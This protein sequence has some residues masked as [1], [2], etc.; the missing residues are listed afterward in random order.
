M[1]VPTD[2]R[3]NDGN[4]SVLPVPGTENSSESSK[5]PSSSSKESSSRSKRRDSRSKSPRGRRHRSKS[6]SIS[7]SNRGRQRDPRLRGRRSRSPNRGPR[8]PPRSRK[9]GS[10]DRYRSSRR[11]WSPRKK[12]PVSP[13][14][15]QAVNPFNMPPPQIYS[16]GYNYTQP[17][18]PPAPYASY[19]YSMQTQAPFN[20]Y[21][22]AGVMQPVP[23]GDDFQQSGWGHP[24]HMAIPPPTLVIPPPIQKPVETEEEKL[25][26]EA[27]VAK[28]KKTQR[29]TL[30][31]Q[32][33]DYK[34][35]AAA[36]KRELNTLKE[37]RDD[38]TS[39]GEPP[40]PT[41]KGFI[42]EN[43]RL[44][45]QIDNKITSIENVIEVL[46]NIIGTE[47]T[48]PTPS[49]PPPPTP[50]KSKKDKKK[51]SNDTSD[52]DSS[53]ERLK[54]KALESLRKKKGND[55]KVAEL[56]NDDDINA[57]SVDDKYKCAQKINYVHYDPQ[58]HWCKQCNIFPKTAKDFL[59]H[60][61][62]KEHQDSQKIIEPPWHDKQVNDE[63]PNYPDAPTKRTPIRGLQF[64]V[65]TTGWYCT[66][67]SIW[68]GD[69]H[70]ASL[71]LKSQS[72]ANNYNNYTNSN[73]HFEVDWM[74]ERHKAYEEVRQKT[75]L[76]IADR[77]G[78]QQ[79]QAPIVPIPMPVPPPNLTMEQEVI[80]GIPLQLQ[81]PTTHKLDLDEGK[82]KKKKK[83]SDEK[84]DKKK[85]KRSK[86]RRQSSSSSSSSDS[87]DSEANTPGEKSRE[88]TSHSIRVAMRNLLKQQ[89]EKKL[90]ES[91]GKWT[92]VQQAQLTEP[93]P[94][95]P[96]ISTNGE[97]DNRRDDLMISQW[98]N[99]EPII[100]EDEKKLLEQ[101][102][103]RLKANS[104]E[105]EVNGRKRSKERSKEPKERNRRRRSRSRSQSRSKR[106]RSRDRRRSRSR[107]RRRSRSRSRGRF[108]SRSRSTGRWGRR[109]SRSR[110]R[111][112][113]G[114]VEKPIVRYPEFR[115]RVP[116]KEIEKLDRKKGEK[117]R[118]QDEPKNASS[119]R[120]DNKKTV[121][122]LKNPNSNK[123]LPFI[124][125]MP[126]FK[127]QTN[128]EEV[129]KTETT[130]ESVANPNYHA[131]YYEGS[132]QQMPM[133]DYDD[134]MPDPMQFVSLMGPAPPPPPMVPPPPSTVDKNEPVLPP[135]I[136]EADADLVRKT[137][138][139]APLPRKGPLPQDFQD[140]LSII[141]DQ[142][143]I[144]DPET[145]KINL[146]EPNIEADQQII[147]MQIVD[148][149]SQHTIDLYQSSFPLTGLK[150][151][152]DLSFAE[153]VDI[154][155]PMPLAIPP[156][157]P[158]HVE[159]SKTIDMVDEDPIVAAKKLEDSALMDDL[160]M[161]GIDA[162]DLAA[163]CI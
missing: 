57:M 123:K 139:D 134:L 35:R 76:A 21:P 29:A 128:E 122:V 162:S 4:N 6:R 64:F 147:P 90:E 74:G 31:K 42:K 126:V 150:T 114:R 159:V 156:P 121:I 109:W 145:D 130:T 140:A 138:S 81:I 131:N 50:V 97:N 120:T 85:K 157:P 73:P 112:R 26:R 13:P 87:S 115:P 152:A 107:E 144:P 28:E 72:H 136:D 94:P 101:L 151:D 78:L 34:R 102:K 103:G 71:H 99:P 19:D 133:E 67:C 44:Q 84:K 9:S 129:K 146:P 53:P 88:D 148:E 141:F 113:G 1:D 95:P 56:R 33:E 153:D 118:D 66:I 63:M 51:K 143:T 23:P 30:G 108:R 43:D 52:D 18:A 47:D 58:M 40:S 119:S 79:Q 110:S 12:G 98:N 160:A 75:P 22:N 7:P 111:S 91:G 38:L 89:T 125:R 161:L 2:R 32:R 65:P 62:S 70:C 15:I 105:R 25:K 3:L 10:R 36:L 96:T 83:K 8:S 106:S 135:G 49:P 61:H 104:K 137:I 5:K 86:K 149:Q 100:T 92:V 46:T 127:R 59:I 45:L 27:A 14:P 154:P 55:L 60:L 17:Y 155:D 48:S 54:N 39:G 20:S 124:G 158:P 163:Q 41:T 82:K 69:L 117:K 77:P 116:E 37:Q 24:S 11:N 93:A 132:V 80:E 142:K 68:M 16:D